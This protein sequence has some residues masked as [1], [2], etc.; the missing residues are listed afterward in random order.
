MVKRRQR[1][2]SSR[3]TIAPP[4]LLLLLLSF[5]FLL[6][7]HHH[8][9]PCALAVTSSLSSPLSSPP[10]P[11]PL[12]SQAAIVRRLYYS[13]SSVSSSASS[14]SSSS[15]TS[16]LPSSPSSPHRATY[17][18]GSAGLAKQQPLLLNSRGVA[19]VT[20]ISLHQMP[21]FN[22]RLGSSSSPSSGSS[23]FSKNHNSSS[24]PFPMSTVSASI[25]VVSAGAVDSSSS[26]GIL[27]PSPSSSSVNVLAPP[28][29]STSTLTTTT[30]TTTTTSTKR[31]STLSHRQGKSVVDLEPPPSR[32]SEEEVEAPIEESNLCFLSHGGSSE[33]F[34][35]NEAMPVDSVIGTIKTTGEMGY[36][37]T[38]LI[39][40]IVNQH[41]PWSLDFFSA[42]L[43]GGGPDVMKHSTHSELEIQNRSNGCSSIESLKQQWNGVVIETRR[44]TMRNELNL[45]CRACLHFHHHR[46]C[47]NKETVLFGRKEEEEKVISY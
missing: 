9:A 33:T 45:C 10:P 47:L 8:L 3:Q 32:K 28:S 44:D 2:Q 11:S 37:F 13:S 29:T 24:V 12:Q 36:L 41:K 19:K 27:S 5:S 40:V 31:P 21:T 25:P 46:H 1:L 7:H 30:T 20:P 26:S 16:R 22:V 38:I 4:F 35:V 23:Q 15:S 39:I 34:T 42:E 14:S 18:S 43:V 6:F 17:N